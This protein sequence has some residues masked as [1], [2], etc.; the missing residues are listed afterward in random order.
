MEP[1]EIQTPGV[2]V[3][4]LMREIQERVEEK[5][6]QGI[7]NQYS[8]DRVTKL[9]LE[10]IKDET[11]Y[12]QWLLKVANHSWDVNIGDPQ[13]VSKGGIFGKPEVWLK[14]IIWHLL[15]F[16]T[17]RLFSQQKEFNSQVAMA[18]GLLSKRIEKLEE[19]SGGKK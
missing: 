3:K 18:L 14:K 9:E 16:Y 12:L 5:K 13:I 2:D 7:Y 15:K 10:S 11:E 17:Y 4:E 1:F 19:K 6:A 8:L